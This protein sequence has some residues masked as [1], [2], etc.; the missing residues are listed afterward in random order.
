MEPERSLPH[1]QVPATRPYPEL[2]G[3]T[4][5]SAQVRG[6]LYECFVTLY[7]FTTRTC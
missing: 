2:L 6:L 4:K 7:V 3:R 5:V 1:S